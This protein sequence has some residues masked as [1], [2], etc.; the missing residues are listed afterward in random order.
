MVGLARLPAM[1]SSALTLTCLLALTAC[2]SADDTAETSTTTDAETSS[3][4]T[5]QATETET[6]AETE[7]ETGGEPAVSVSS[8]ELE[9]L[10]E[11]EMTPS[12]SAVAGANGI[13]VVHTHHWNNC[14]FMPAASASLDGQT[15][16][17]TYSHLGDECDCVCS[18]ELSYTIEG[19]EPGTWTVQVGNL[20]A[21]V[22]L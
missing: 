20:S 9:H 18:W 21:D 11:E 4:T 19:L 15:I 1:R 6:G 17:L 10:G 7:T 16:D 3:S 14:C 13:D 22:E 5:G 2:P 12:L 8:I